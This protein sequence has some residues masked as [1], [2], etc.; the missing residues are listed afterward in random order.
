MRS[1]DLIKSSNGKTKWTERIVYFDDLVSDY[2]KQVAEN[3]KKQA[4][5][6]NLEEKN[7]SLSTEKGNIL[8]NL[9]E[10]EY[11]LK[12]TETDYDGLLKKYELEKSKNNKNQKKIGE[13]NN[14]IDFLKNNKRAPSLEE[15]KDYQFKRKRSISK[16]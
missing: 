4:I 14:T 5:I 12:Q 1:L 2:N 9:A 6:D 13:L 15:L 3:F 7:I 10:S 8:K 16:W 11:N